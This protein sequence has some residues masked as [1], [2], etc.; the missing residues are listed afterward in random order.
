MALK[1]E[2]RLFTLLRFSGSDEE[3]NAAWLAERQNGVGG[4]DVAAIMGLSPW[5]APY[6]LWAEKT[7]RVQAEDISGKEAVAMGTEL[8]SDV[9]EMYK[10]RNPQAR[11]RVVNAI[12]QSIKRP[13]ARASVDGLTSDPELGVGV[14]EIKTGGSEKAW[15][16]GVPLYYQTQV[17]HYLSVTGYAFADVAALIGDHGLHYHQIRIMRDEEDIAAVESAVDTFWLDC[18]QGDKVPLAVA[19]DAKAVTEVGSPGN[20]ELMPS[21]SRDLADRIRDYVVAQEEARAAKAKADDL[22]TGIKAALGQYKGCVTDT[23]KVTLARFERT[24]IDSKKLK[25]EY[26]DVFAECS[27]TSTSNRFSVKSL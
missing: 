23:N 14:L 2:G 16:N 27:K 1:N 12:A 11:V 21:V 13:W 4:S 26:P 20:D 22:A 9:V 5:K 17:A 7:G 24:S 15:E 6:T 18:V 3:V 25:D 19:A 8:E 10:R